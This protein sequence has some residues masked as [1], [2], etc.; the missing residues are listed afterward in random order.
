MPTPAA[1]EPKIDPVPAPEECRRLMTAMQ[2]Q[3]HIRDHSRQVCRV[4]EF[5]TDA[6]I[7]AG[8]PLSRP[9]ITAAA[10]LHDI[11]KTRSLDTGENHAATGAAYLASLG[12][13]RVSEIVRQHVV[14]DI[15]DRNGQPSE[16]EVVNY[17]DKRVLHDA[18]TDLDTRM[19]YIRDR[20]GTT[21]AH[22][23]RIATLWR[24][25]T[26]LERRLFSRLA[27]GPDELVIKMDARSRPQQEG[28]VQK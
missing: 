12:Y 7:A 4:A 10:L 15:Q 18:I 14:L 6:L 8:L 21:P 28:L 13:R 27:F 24:T 20:Y 16:A 11:T 19:A 26:Q 5:L 23:E 25:T 1:P 3:P 17:A 2:M 9:L 22:L